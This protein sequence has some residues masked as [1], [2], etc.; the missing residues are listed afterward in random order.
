MPTLELLPDEEE[1]QSPFLVNKQQK[2]VTND[3]YAL[4][5]EE[6]GALLDHVA[7]EFA[8]DPRAMERLASAF[9]K[10]TRTDDFRT[11]TIQP[12]PGFVIKTHIL[13][14]KKSK[15]KTRVYVNVCHAAD[16]PPPP[17]MPESQIQ[18]AM[19]AEP[20]ATY[21]VPLS[22]TPPRYE[23]DESG[24]TIMIADACINTQAYLR[25]ERDLDY[26]LYIIELSIE[27]VEEKEDLEL[28]REFSMPS[29][30]SK[31]TIPPRT[32]RLPKPALISAIKQKKTNKGWECKPE[33]THKGD[34]LA[35]VLP[36]MPSTSPSSWTLDIEP[37]QLI[38]A[39]NSAP[40]K[41]AL[42][43]TVD[44]QHPQTTAKFYKESRHLVVNL[45]VSSRSRKQY[46]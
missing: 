35:V 45:I 24:N 26:R 8:A 5:K 37:T 44:I 7:A 20:D 2:P 10:E 6:Q 38:L 18:K 28:S 9:L 34:R 39:V 12:E 13:R 11:A 15:P 43:T 22:L 23:Q 4:S 25:T 19:N 40:T 32:L 42:P 1:A 31:G 30:R 27:W 3:F 16:I 33:I 41:I 29:I 46:L 14:S 17:V 36:N 21:R